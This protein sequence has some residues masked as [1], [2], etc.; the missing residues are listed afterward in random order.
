MYIST[1]NWK[2]YIDRL[3][4]LDKKAG[5]LMLAWIQKNGFADTEALIDYAYAVATRYGEGSAALSAQMYEAIAEVQGK[6]IQPAEVA[7][8]PSKDEVAKTVNGVTKWSRKPDSLAN[9][10]GRLVKRTGADTMLNNAERDGAQ[11]AWVPSGD[12]CAF[13]ITLA[14]RGWQYMS[15]KARKNGHAEHIHAN[16]DC[17]YAVRFDSKS[18]VSGYDPQVYADMYYSA[19]GSSP[20]EKINSIRRM[21]YQENKDRINAQ[22]RAAYAERKQEN[23]KKSRINEYSV[24]NTI[25]RAKEYRDKFNSIT[26]D[27]AVNS[28]LYNKAMDVLDHRGGTD[29]E[30][31]HLISIADGLVKGTQTKTEYYNGVTEE[32]RHSH[33]WYNESLNSAIKLNPTKSLISLHNHPGSLPPSGGDFESQFIHGYKG[34]VIA[35][36]N[37]DVYYY[38]VGK[39]R[40]SGKLYDLTVDKFMK[41]GYS[42]LEAYTKTLE[43]FA[44]DYGIKWRRI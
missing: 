40:F 38:E 33:V 32:L 1:K 14:S 8:T 10:V 27:D 35:C 37:G 23:E 34:G 19:E 6:F 31:M 22:K 9:A 41:Q 20:D 4:A 28:T 42:D 7:P 39:K 16:C 12:T 3:S 24:N 30:D 11:F 25:V 13:C 44:N 15:D 26:E 36:H 29:Y 2:N 21:K 17:T 5:E 43:Q 18:G